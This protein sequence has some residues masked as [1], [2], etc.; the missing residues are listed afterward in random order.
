MTIKFYSPGPV[1]D[2]QDSCFFHTWRRVHVWRQRSGHLCLSPLPSSETLSVGICLFC[3]TIKIIT[4]PSDLQFWNTVVLAMNWDRLDSIFSIIL[5]PLDSKSLTFSVPL[6]KH[7]CSNHYRH[8]VCLL[9]PGFP[10]LSV[11]LQEQNA[12][13]QK[14]GRSKENQSMVQKQ[15]ERREVV[16]VGRECDGVSLGLT[17]VRPWA[18]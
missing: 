12:T 13:G 2:K 4:C 14:E 18:S 15:L 6:Y 16:G 3:H 5:H 10:T 7:H 8:C 17:K 9:I 1:N 11:V